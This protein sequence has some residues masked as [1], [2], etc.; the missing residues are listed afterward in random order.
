M[1]L[2]YSI[3]LIYFLVLSTACQN[4]SRTD[5][6]KDTRATTTEKKSPV[7]AGQVTDSDQK[8]ILF[9]GNSLTAG[10]GIDPKDAFVGLIDNK[11]DS[12]DLPYKA[13]NSGVSG[14]TTAGGLGRIEWILDQY[15][16]SVFVLELGGNDALRGV[17]PSASKDNLQGIIDAVKNKYPT[18][19]IVLAGMEAPPN[20]GE[21]FRN[22]FRQMYRD[23]AKKNDL[24]LIPFLL[25][26]VGGIPE[27]NLKDGIHPTEEGHKIVAEVIWKV[28]ENAL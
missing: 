17:D 6:S 14:E 9:F 27:L 16:P 23:L 21:T 24:L 20:M 4:N 25:E 12:L 18:T 10:Y 1:Q 13:V 26:G 3:T 22:S 28:L 8:T 19:S 2:R 15:E 5:S 11:L 7:P